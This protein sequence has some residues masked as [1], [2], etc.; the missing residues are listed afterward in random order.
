[1][2]G[3]VQ[4]L[5]PER[6]DQPHHQKPDEGVQLTGVLVLVGIPRQCSS[7]RHRFVGILE[8]RNQ[9]DRPD[10]V[11]GQKGHPGVLH[12]LRAAL[13][14]V[15]LD[16]LGQV[17]Q[18]PRGVFDGGSM[19]GDAKNRGQT[20]RFPCAVA[21]RHDAQLR[22]G[23]PQHPDTLQHSQPRRGR[24]GRL[25]DRQRWRG[26]SLGS[27]RVADAALLQKDRLDDV[28][29][30]VDDRR[31]HVRVR[32]RARLSVKG[33]NLVVDGVL[34]HDLGQ[35]RRH[36]VAVN[37]LLSGHHHH[38]VFQAP[39]R[40][41]GR[42][43][44][45]VSHDVRG[46][47]FGVLLSFLLE[48]AV[49][50]I[51]ALKGDR[52]SGFAKGIDVRKSRLQRALDEVG[53]HP[54]ADLFGTNDRFGV[55]AEVVGQARWLVPVRS[56]QL[57]A[58]A[59]EGLEDPSQF[60]NRPSLDR[61]VF[62]EFSDAAQ[63]VPVMECRLQPFAG[64]LCRFLIRGRFAFSLL[65]D[66][67]LDSHRLTTIDQVEGF[68][69]AH[70]RYPHLVNPLQGRQGISRRSPVPAID[71]ILVGVADDFHRIRG[72]VHVLLRQNHVLF[73]LGVL[74]VPEGIVPGGTG[75][76]AVLSRPRVLHVNDTAVQPIDG[77]FAIHDRVEFFPGVLHEDER[78]AEVV[79]R[80]A[81]HARGVGGGA[82]QRVQLPGPLRQLVAALARR[83][84]CLFHLR[85]ALGQGVDATRFGLNHHG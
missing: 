14:R 4:G 54:A 64:L 55:L 56:A 53:V 30:L 11:D 21:D 83:G 13:D 44:G 27:R 32:G 15:F 66:H 40:V 39:H 12:P 67:P 20:L 51:D 7:L 76:L 6:V 65:F 50:L 36:N 33:R 8:G 85:Q 34:V 81:Q 79:R 68:Q 9:L 63:K 41:A 19:D 78:R 26:F 42:R 71:E 77:R 52:L 22:Q 24:R 62:F 80:L 46:K 59:P 17:L 84:G 49:V 48:P 75:P 10:H 69:D 37:A 38:A 47:L 16:G 1:M 5:A 82:R 18:R 60:S 43:I 70:R 31:G 74:A 25:P 73:L 23:G 45:G 29:G 58:V 72:R 61:L 3:V 57:K 35:R 28:H 2:L